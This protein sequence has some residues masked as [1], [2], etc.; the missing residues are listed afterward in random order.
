MATIQFLGAAGTVTG[1]KFLLE[2]DG[3]KILFD[4]G[5]FQ[6]A[7]ELRLRNWAAPPVDP[8]TLD[9]VVLTHAHVDH[10]GF[11]PRLVKE[12]YRGPILATPGTRDLCAILLPDSAYLQEEEARYANQK[13]Y[14]KHHP[15]LPL[16]SSND[17]LAALKLFETF[18]Y[19]RKREILPGVF[20]EFL[21]SGH[22]L[23]SAICVVELESTGQR[24]VFTGDLGRAHA[25]ILCD[26][27]RVTGA[28]TLVVESTYGDRLHPDNDPVQTLAAIVN[29]V[30]ERR[31]VL[32]I[33]AFAVGRTQELLYDL[34]E[35]ERAGRIPRVDLFVDS[36][37]ACDATPLYLAHIEDHDPAMREILARG[38]S[39]FTTS[40]THFV[41]STKASQ[42][43]NERAGPA[44]VLSASGMATGGRVLHHLAHRLPDPKNAV[45]FVGYQS[46]GTRG[47]RLVDGEAA[48]KIHGEVVL[49]KAEILTLSGFS[50]HADSRELLGWMDGFLEPPRQTLL[51]HGEEKALDAL[52][53]RVRERGWN[54][55]APRHL[56]T[57]PLAEA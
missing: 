9:R 42:A 24:V 44:V 25:P 6:G 45:L 37:M 36:P 48:I 12:G 41:T 56:E 21:R 32:V 8:A 53:R 31:G 28:T 39:P 57:V 5:L 35:L 27:E 29:R 16:Y 33:P 20:L 38:E 30:A 50:A 55:H 4:C 54:V 1:S 23:G 43:L 3:R 2:H 17:A 13:R 51:V 26:P 18:G 47:R 15:A 10:T 14:S 40:K 34:R 11:L 46:Q 7:K 52:G 19:G 22:I 49:V